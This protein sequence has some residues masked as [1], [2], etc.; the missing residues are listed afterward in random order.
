MA[1]IE[2]NPNEEVQQ[3]PIREEFNPPV[4]SQVDIAPKVEV[5]TEERKFWYALRQLSKEVKSLKNSPYGEYK[6]EGEEYHK[7]QEQTPAY[8]EVLG[9][10]DKRNAAV[11]AEIDRKE[12]IRE[13]RDFFRDNPEFKDYS[14]KIEKTA[15]HP[16]FWDIS[17]DFIAKG[18]AYDQA[19]K[20]GAERSKQADDEAVKS[21][22]GGSPFKPA[23]ANTKDYWDM[24]D[25]EFEQ[26]INKT[27]SGR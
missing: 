13:V 19:Q 22:I 26:E 9:S 10:I 27:K 18:Y 24:N 20:V 17:V 6:D 21:K 11:L 1:E 25:D 16:K 8:D 12:R 23:D 15:L 4:R 7:P 2:T 3:E 5:D 14:A